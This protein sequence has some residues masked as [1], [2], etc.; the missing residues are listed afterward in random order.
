LGQRPSEPPFA[1]PEGFTSVREVFFANRE[2]GVKPLELGC[3]R[4]SGPPLGP[5]LFAEFKRLDEDGEV[6]SRD[7]W[8]RAL[9]LI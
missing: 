9:G 3:D 2:Q 5:D 7:R 6:R 1:I 8:P 4:L